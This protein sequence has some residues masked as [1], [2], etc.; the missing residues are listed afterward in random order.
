MVYISKYGL[1]GVSLLAY[2]RLTCS[3]IA[4]K[5]R[6]TNVS[7]FD[8]QTFCETNLD[9]KRPVFYSQNLNW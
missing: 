7:D 9:M 2:R 3:K 4:P 8:T 1:V 5:L 6:N